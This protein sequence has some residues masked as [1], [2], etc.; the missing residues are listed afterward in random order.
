MLDYADLISGTCIVEEEN[1]RPKVVL[2]DT[3]AC[4]PGTVS[5]IVVWP[6]HTCS[7]ALTHKEIAFYACVNISK[8]GT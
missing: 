5:E 4:M 1:L 8:L 3:H 7:H 2:G 6:H